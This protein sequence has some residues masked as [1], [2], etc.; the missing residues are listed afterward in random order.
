[1][2]KI[3]FFSNNVGKQEE[4]KTLFKNF[5][6]NIFFPEDFKITYEPK[7]VGN[8]FANNAKIKS[9]FG[10]EKTHIP[11]F[12]D[13]SGISIEALGWKPNIMSKRFIDSFKNST[14]CFNY[15]IKKTKQSGKIKA[16]FKTS[17]CYTFEK[18]YHV[19]FEGKIEG[20]ISGKIKGK[21]GFGYDPIFEELSSKLTFAEMD[22]DLKDLYSHRG[23]ALKKI[24][25]QLLKI[26]A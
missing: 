13:D 1:M 11:C 20:I 12:A 2:N 26:F 22:N 9:L 14:E 23:K 6:I 17:I 21:N 19:L 25:P 8:S 24:I 16:Y 18:N 15:I 4:I 7:E 3:F 5:R 10:Y